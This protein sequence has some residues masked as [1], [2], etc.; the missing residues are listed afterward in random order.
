MLS[1]A[2]VEAFRAANVSLS[3][4]AVA[5]L[6][7]FWSSLN[8]DRPEAARDALLAFVPALTDQFGESAAGVAA[9]FF[10]EWRVEAVGSGFTAV[11]APTVPVLA[12]EKRVRF[13]AAHLFTDD[14]AGMLRFLDGAVQEYVLQPGR[15]TITQ[16]AVADPKSRGWARNVRPGACDFCR[17]LSGRGAVYSEATV[18]FKA[19]GDCHCVPAPDWG[20]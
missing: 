18:K 11:M 7:G 15:D 16:S 5:E 13:G 14:P 6:T 2:D 10:D 9:D 3:S 8:L 20:N 1:R 17:L 19:H 12:V 4:L